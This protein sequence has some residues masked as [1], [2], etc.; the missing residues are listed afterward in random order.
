MLCI[1]EIEHNI[2]YQTMEN[3]FNVS[4][5]TVSYDIK[6]HLFVLITVRTR[7]LVGRL[8]V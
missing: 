1:E 7:Y 4:D 6:K 2:G 8:L 5:G 3:S